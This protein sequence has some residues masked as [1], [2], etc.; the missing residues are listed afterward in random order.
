MAGECATLWIGDR[1]GPVERACLKSVLHHGHSLALYCYRPP[2]GVPEGVELR[3]AAAILPESEIFFHASGSV[4]IFADWFRLELQ[5]HGAGT[6]VDTDVYLLR[7]LDTVRPYLFGKE[8][9]GLINNAVLRVP[10]DSPLL[11]PLIGIFETGRIPPWLPWRFYLPAAVQ[12]R[13][14]GRADFARLPFGTTGPF[15][16]TAAARRFGVSCQALPIEVFN[17]VPWQK[18]DWITD[19][20]VSLDSVT[21]E[22]TV[23]VHLWN[24]CIRHLKDEPAPAGSFLERLQREGRE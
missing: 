17:P 24:E 8:E 12:Q 18:A 13:F 22:E 7:P 10:S 11:G 6:W 1:L 14:K 5:R 16:L 2:R 15:A 19:P 9:E 21:T 20:A 4:A 3:D 23:A